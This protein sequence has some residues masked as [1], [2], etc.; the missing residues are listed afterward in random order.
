VLLPRY[1]RLAGAAVVPVLLGYF[2]LSLPLVATL[3]AGR[4]TR[5]S[6]PTD[7][8]HLR[9]IDTLIVFDGD[10]RRGRA[11]ETAAIWRAS[12]PSLVLVSGEAWLIEPLVEAGVSRS[13]LQ[14]DKSGQNTRDQVLLSTRLLATR[15]ASHG[16][17]V[18]SRLQMPRIE[19]LARAIGLRATLVASPVDAEP[20]STGWLRY[21]PSYAALRVSR[22]AIYEHAAFV[23]YRWRGWISLPDP[24]MACAADIG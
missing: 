5:C 12:A 24:L 9:G 16:A 2:V 22:D 8:T 13:S 23:Y 18:A 17:I 14:R 3:I 21:V 19:A 4:L 11:R 10:N 6:P 15:P 7:I 1:R 20:P